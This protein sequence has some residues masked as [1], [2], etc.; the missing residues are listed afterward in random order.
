MPGRTGD[1]ARPGRGVLPVG[2]GLVGPAGAPRGAVTGNQPQAALR[3]RGWHLPPSVARVGGPSVAC[4]SCRPCRVWPGGRDFLGPHCTD[5]TA[6][7]CPAP[8]ARSHPGLSRRRPLWPA[9]TGLAGCAV[10]GASKGLGGCG[11]RPAEG[12]ACTSFTDGA[13]RGSGRGAGPGLHA[14][15]TPAVLGRGQRGGPCGAPR[16]PPGRRARAG[17]GAALSS[18]LC[19]R[20]TPPRPGESQTPAHA[21]CTSVPALGPLLPTLVTALTSNSAQIFLELSGGLVCVVP[22]SSQPPDPPR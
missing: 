7:H 16:S 10:P 19:G 3:L 11:P 2:T 14:A 9:G 4:P 5:L 20:Q 22:G 1:R 8:Q 15:P 21:P 18:G 6:P 12:P 17:A 13:R